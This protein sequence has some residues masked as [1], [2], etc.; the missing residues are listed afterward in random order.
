MSLF[1]IWKVLHTLLLQAEVQDLGIFQRVVYLIKVVLLKDVKNMPI[2][3][4]D[5]V[6]TTNY[7][8]EC[9][10]LCKEDWDSFETSWDFE[11]HPLI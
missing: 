2:I 1:G 5:N 10:E 8:K 7:A 4:P 11:K 3:I 9:V 6:D